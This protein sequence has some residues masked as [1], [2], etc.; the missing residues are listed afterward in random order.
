M[1]LQDSPTANSTGPPA[2]GFHCFV[3]L[4]G[5]SAAKFLAQDRRTSRV[6]SGFTASSPANPGK[7]SQASIGSKHNCISLK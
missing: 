1:G 7:S 6:N 3:W 2:R 5:V 4:P